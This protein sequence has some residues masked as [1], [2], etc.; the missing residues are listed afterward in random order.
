MSVHFDRP[1]PYVI[2]KFGVNIFQTRSPCTTCEEY[3]IVVKK[4]GSTL[5]IYIIYIYIYIYICTCTCT[6]TTLFRPSSL[7]LLSLSSSSFPPS[8]SLSLSLPLSP[9]L[10]LSP[11]PSPPSLSLSPPLSLPLPLPLPLLQGRHGLGSIFVWAAGNG[12]R[13]G[14]SCNCDGYAVSMYTISIGSVSQNDRFPWYAELCSSTLSSTYSSGS[15]SEKQIVSSCAVGAVCGCG[16]GC[17][18]VCMCVCVFGFV[19]VGGLGLGVGVGVYVWF[20]LVW[21]WT[22]VVYMFCGA[23]TLHAIYCMRQQK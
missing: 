15:G 4:T 6:C 16:C 18:C 13:D 19:R 9:S 17:G 12:G 10:S 2:V 14:D 8:L 23:R 7:F 5:R 3:I 21:V 22:C 1:C 20:G 11:S